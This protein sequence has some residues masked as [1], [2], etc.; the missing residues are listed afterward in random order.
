MTADVLPVSHGRRILIWPTQSDEMREIA[1]QLGHFGYEAKLCHDLPQLL[2][3]CE[4]TGSIGV[5]LDCDAVSQLPPE[6]RSAVQALS[7]KA[8]MAGLSSSGDIETRLAA[9][10]MGCHAFF[11]RPLDMTALL[12]TLDRLT[13]PVQAEAGRVLIVDDS[14]SMVAFYSATLTQAGFV[15]QSVTDPLKALDALVDHT[16]E[17]ILLDMHMPGASGRP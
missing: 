11:T 14:P 3:Q 5:L 7:Q 8:A 4:P 6:Q 10:R 13:A 2:L 1:F 12:D 16:P 9:V 17:L 15:C